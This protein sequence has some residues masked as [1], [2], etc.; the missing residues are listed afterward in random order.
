[1]TLYVIKR[2]TI[3]GRG[4]FARVDIAKGEPIIEYKGTRCTWD[5]AA[6]HLIDDVDPCHTFIMS[7]DCGDVIDGARKG[8]ASRYIN[9]ACDPNCEAIEDD[10]ERIWIQAKRKIK[11]G[12]ELNYNYGLVLQGRTTKAQRA[13]YRCLCGSKKCRGSMLQKP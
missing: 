7:L 3:H 4:I 2:S 9:H 5:E 11:A 8:N 10:E 1:M 12:E 13:G 6:E